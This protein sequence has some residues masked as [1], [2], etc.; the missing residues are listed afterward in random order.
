MRTYIDFTS[1]SVSIKT[2]G[3]RYFPLTDMYGFHV[4]KFTDLKFTKRSMLSLS[5]SLFDPI[6]W[7]LPVIMAF[8]I[9]I[10]KLYSLNLNWDDIEPKVKG[11]LSKYIE[12][13]C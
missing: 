9:H 4:K 13:L 3:I 6:G 10:H 5:A 8:R 1:E 12:F 11:K 2:L 7:I